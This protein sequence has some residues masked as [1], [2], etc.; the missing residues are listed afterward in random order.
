MLHVSD[1]T[2]FQHACIET[3]ES[4]ALIIKTTY[5]LHSK[6]VSSLYLVWFSIFGLQSEYITIEKVYEYCQ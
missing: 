3:T 6:A 2:E 5:A 4:I 1:N